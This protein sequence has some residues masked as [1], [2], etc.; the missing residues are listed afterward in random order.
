MDGKPKILSVIAIDTNSNQE[1]TYFAGLNTSLGYSNSL[2][3]ND[4]N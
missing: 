4:N 2:D 3:K 1:Y